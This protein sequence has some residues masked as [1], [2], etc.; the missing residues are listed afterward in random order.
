MKIYVADMNLKNINVSKMEN[1]CIMREQNI[2]RIYSEKGIIEIDK[3]GKLWKMEIVDDNFSEYLIDNEIKLYIDKS[4]LKRKEEVFQII[5]E[6]VSLI[7]KKKIYN[8][9]QKSSVKLV[10]EYANNDDTDNTIITDI[11]FESDIDIQQ[12]CVKEDIVTFL[13]LLNFVETI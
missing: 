6:H 4:V 2:K 13:I 8:L 12:N 7:I 10:V 3:S 11:Y 9:S 5:P 1:K